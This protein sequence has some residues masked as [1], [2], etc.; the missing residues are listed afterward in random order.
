MI[1]EDSQPDVKWMSLTQAQSPSEGPL[2]TG[3]LRLWG[4]N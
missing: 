3:K 2:N 4:E 1:S